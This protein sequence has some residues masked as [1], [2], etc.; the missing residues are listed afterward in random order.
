VNRVR[1]WL[2]GQSTLTLATVSATGAPAA[3]DLYYAA[4]HDLH[5][6]FISEQG[7]RHA[8]H[9]GSG[10]PVAATVHGQAWDWREIRGIQLEGDCRPVESTRERAAALALYGRKFTF[11]HTFAAVLPRHTLFV[12]S[13]RWIRWLDNGA[14]FGAREEWA[15]E[16]G[17]WISQDK[18]G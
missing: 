11:L 3:A 17:Q 18:R 1:D 12:I 16:A 13:P 2:E 15:W 5:I 10:A 7:A 9:I 14:G 6:Y 8:A 4:D